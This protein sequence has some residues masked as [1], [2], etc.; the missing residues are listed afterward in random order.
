M[1]CLLNTAYQFYNLSNAESST[2]FNYLF[3]FFS[4]QD[5]F[6]LLHSRMSNAIW[7]NGKKELL[8]KLRIFTNDKDIRIFNLIAFFQLK[9]LVWNWKTHHK[10]HINPISLSFGLSVAHSSNDPTTNP[11]ARE[12]SRE[13]KNLTER[14]NLHP[15]NM[16]SNSLSVYLLPNLTPIISRLAKQNGLK[17]FKVTV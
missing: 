17:F 12:A 7:C 10:L 6:I 3:I 13:V 4:F 1:A 15:P 11:P 8:R 2:W 16:V 9:S 14:K 5:K